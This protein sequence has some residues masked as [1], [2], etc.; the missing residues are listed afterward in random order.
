MQPPRL[1]RAALILALAATAACTREVAAGLEEAEANRGVVALARSGIDAEKIADGQS[2][3]RFR[4][5]VGRDE[6]TSAIAVLSGEEIPRLRPTAAKDAPFVASPEA[7]RAARV[8]QTAQAI[9]RSLASVDGVMDARVHLDVPQIDPLTSALAPDAK[10]ARATASVLVRHRGATPPIGV[11][12]IRRLVAGAVSG[13]AAE[14]VAVVTV[15]VPLPTSSADRQL[16]WVGPIGVSRGSL[17][18]FRALAAAALGGLFVLSAALVALAIK[19]RRTRD[20]QGDAGAEPERAGRG[21][22]R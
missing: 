3:G 14:G 18:A 20:A 5:V 11:E 9:E 15:S 4:L 1:P 17:P 7:D 10:G 22:S 12:E 6:A 19:L 21:A 2:D 13:L 8:G 16:A